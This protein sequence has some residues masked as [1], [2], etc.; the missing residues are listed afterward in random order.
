MHSVKYKGGMHHKITTIAT[1]SSINKIYRAIRVRACKLGL[2]LT[3]DFL[4]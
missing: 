1:D 4:A 2:V 3:F